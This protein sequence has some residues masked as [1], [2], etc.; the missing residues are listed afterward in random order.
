MTHEIDRR[1]MPER[2]VPFKV[3]EPPS[4]EVF[5]E[6]MRSRR[7]DFPAPDGPMMAVEENHASGQYTI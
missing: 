4:R 2:G 6:D 5:L 3:T 1:S 7:V